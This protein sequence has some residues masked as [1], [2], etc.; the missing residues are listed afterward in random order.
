MSFPQ[1]VQGI[2]VSLS[3]HAAMAGGLDGPA[4]PSNPHPLI[5]AGCTAAAPGPGQAFSGTVLEV[6]DGATLCVA[7][8]ATPDQWILVRLS[9][10]AGAR[11]R[12][13]LMAAAFAKRLTCVAGRASAHGV[14]AQCAIDGV[15]LGVVSDAPAVVLDAKA[16]R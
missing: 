4:C 1:I 3:V 13:T 7:Q 12:S 15:D 2:A 5:V 6:I 16:W 10:Q 14:V 9:G 11:S 8:G